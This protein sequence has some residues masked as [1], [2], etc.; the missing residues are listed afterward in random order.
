MSFFSTLFVIIFVLAVIVMFFT[1]EL[2]TAF[3][4]AIALCYLGFQ[5]FGTLGAVVGF[6]L[7]G[8]IGFVI[9]AVFEN[10]FSG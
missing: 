3:A 8:I 7:G 9:A 10:F 1:G 4:S 5:L 2:W 6:V